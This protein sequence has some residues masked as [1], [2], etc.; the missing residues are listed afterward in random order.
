MV[1]E[2]NL[3]T[4]LLTESLYKWCFFM[5]VA[6]VLD[7]YGNWHF[8]ISNRLI[9]GKEKIGIDFCVTAFILTKVLQ[10]SSR[11]NPLPTI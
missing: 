2:L 5:V 9:M 3:F 10:K 4:M 7:Y 1:D 8:K 6:C 11:S